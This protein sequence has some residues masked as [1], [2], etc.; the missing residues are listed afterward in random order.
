MMPHRGIYWWILSPLIKKSIANKFS[1]SLARSSI[2]KGKRQYKNILKKVPDLGKGNPM[3]FNA[4]FA[5]V[6]IAIWQG[7]E[8]TIS[9]GS[10]GIIMEDV[11]SRLKYLFIFNNCNSKK[12]EK[13]WYR[14]MRKYEKWTQGKMDKYPTT[15]KVHF[16][17]KAHIDGSYY[18]FT[19]CPICDFCNRE[20]ISEIMPPLC[21]TDK[22]MFQMQRGILHRNYTI[23]NGDAMC[24][25]W[26]VGDEV[27]SPK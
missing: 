19:S 15:W 20:G 16:D 8:K 22:L 7:S 3:A 5:Y 11:L 9:P 10:M 26:I 4:Y 21:S 2:K 24:D 6:F 23:A 1:E 27:N 17:E 12:G 14:K 25:Y 18:Y 13:Y